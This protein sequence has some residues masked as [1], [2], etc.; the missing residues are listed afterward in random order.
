MTIKN[1]GGIFLRV[2]DTDR[3][4]TLYNGDGESLSF[5]GSNST[6]KALKKFINS[7]NCKT[8]HTVNRSD[9]H[10]IFKNGMTYTVCIICSNYVLL[11]NDDKDTTQFWVKNNN[12]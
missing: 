12:D 3:G 7:S 6:A 1:T 4:I 10:D 5:F 8:G 9:A 2:V 11:S